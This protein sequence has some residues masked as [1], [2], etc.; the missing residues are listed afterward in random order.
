M[1]N[2]TLFALL[3]LLQPEEI[4][5]L[6]QLIDTALFKLPNRHTD[7]VGLFRYL[8]PILNAKDD[9]P[10]LDKKEVAQALF[11]HRANPDLELRK[12]MSNLMGIVKKFVLVQQILLPQKEEAAEFLQGVQAELGLLRWIK[13]RSTN[14]AFNKIKNQQFNFTSQKSQLLIGQYYQ[15]L[16]EQTAVF[17]SEIGVLFNQRNYSEW[18]L[19]GF[20]REYD[21]FDY[22]SLQRRQQEQERHLIQ[23]LEAL[24]L[25]YYQL[26]LSLVVLAQTNQMMRP[27]QEKIE[28]PFVDNQIEQVEFIL[29][30]LPKHLK[31][32]NAIQLFGAT[33]AMLRMAEKGEV[34]YQQVEDLILNGDLDIPDDI[35]LTIRTM[36]RVYCSVMYNRTGQPIYLQRNFVFFTE[37][38]ER[39]IKQKAGAVTAL[40]FSAAISNALRLGKQNHAWVGDFLERFKNGNN[41]IG[42]EIPRE[43]YKINRA[44]LLLHQGAYR[45]ASNELVGYEWY[46]RLD[47]P[48]I[49][50]LAIRI[51][52]K[53]QI[54]MGRYEEDYTL[55]TLDS[56]E[57]RIVRLVGID[58]QQRQLTLQFLRI[59]KQ[60]CPIMAKVQL[61]MPPAD[62]QTR[63]AAW[64]QEIAQV[65]VAEKA[66]LLEKIEQL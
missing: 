43:V 29:T 64:Q 23:A 52:L 28:T 30:H 12:A 66:W 51:D 7:T 20:W 61:R 34:H 10:E 48:Q 54:E 41:I 18:L 37:N 1:Q 55:R 11:G 8:K 62:V 6:D 59:I 63:K 19:S 2:S 5:L 9:E 27:V 39:E 16:L 24:D 14:S 56:A 4:D 22:Y 21:M 15:S 42:T 53:T 38:L 32:S 33:H 45:E 26:K 3:N 47:E 35:I 40:S 49:L 17:P 60:I 44:H 58:E 36:Q 46:G 25:F 50:L 13:E 65:P 31:K 57:K